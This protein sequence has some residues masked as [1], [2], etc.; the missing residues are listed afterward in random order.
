MATPDQFIVDNTDEHW[1]ALEYVRQWCE[2]SRAIDIATG[3][4]EIGALLALEGHW[5]KVDKI[6]LLIG[7][8]TSRLTADV[9]AEAVDQLQRSIKQERQK[10]DPFLAGAEAIVEA[11]ATGTIEIRVYRSKKFHAKAYITHGRLDVVGSAALVGSS[12]FTRPGLT[13][14]VELNVKF[15]GPKFETSRTG[16]RSTGRKPSLSRRRC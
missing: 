10:E 8:E 15:R 6:R 3:H 12:N 14:N 11:I 16:T 9:I 7:G 13:Q 4:F 1:K 5:Q 2:I